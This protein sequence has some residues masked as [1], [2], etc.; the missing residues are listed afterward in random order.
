MSL[1]PPD[2]NRPSIEHPYDRRVRQQREDEQRLGITRPHIPVS[3]IGFPDT[4]EGQRT[5][6]LAD[7]MN[8]QLKLHLLP[9][10]D[11]QGHMMFCLK[12]SWHYRVLWLSNEIEGALPRKTFPQTGIRPLLPKQAF[13]LLQ[14]RISADIAFYRL[15]QAG[16][17]DI[18]RWCQRYSIDD[19]F[20]D[21]PDPALALFIET[22]QADF[23]EDIETLFR[24]K[25]DFPSKAEQLKQHRTWSK[26]LTGYIETPD[27][28]Y[29]NA[30]WNSGWF[31][32]AVLALKD[33]QAKP[34]LKKPWKQFI[35]TRKKLTPDQWP[36]LTWGHDR[37]FLRKQ[38]N[39]RVSVRSRILEDGSFEYYEDC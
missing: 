29:L 34:H 9:N 24:N 37:L 25:E 36:S 1:H 15:I 4:P 3:V 8:D 38:T 14:L 11:A 30:L 28:A 5:V 39:Q 18:A 12:Q 21:A 32:Y 20:S 17:A 23:Q 16:E 10:T 26:V 22:L 35:R 19:P 2:P 31:G 33:L 13:E 6:D 7:R 27:P